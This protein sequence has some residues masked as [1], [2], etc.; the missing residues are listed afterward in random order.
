MAGA[1]FGIG[2]QASYPLQQTPWG[3]S[4]YGSQVTG[5]YQ[6]GASSL[7]QPIL[8]SLQIATHQIQQLQQL[9]YVQLQQ[10]QQVQQWI[11]V[12]P[13]QI[14]QLQQQFLAQQSPFGATGLPFQTVPAAQQ[15]FP[16]QPGHV[17]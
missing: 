7:L 16:A 10:L 2:S 15:F 8:Q 4:P 11:Q 14:Q 5:S 1:Q 6:A 3:L 13:Q 9:Q 12:V 17:M